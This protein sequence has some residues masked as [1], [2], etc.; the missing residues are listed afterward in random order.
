[1]TWSNAWSQVLVFC[2]PRYNV[3][4]NS[5]YFLHL[6]KYKNLPIIPCHTTR[7]YD[8]WFGVRQRGVRV[9]FKKTEGLGA[10]VI[11]IQKGFLRWGMGAVAARKTKKVA[12]AGTGTVKVKVKP[13]KVI[14]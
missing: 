10:C 2:F 11:A 5:L 6:I 13:A 12:V 8:F 1:M 7:G 14:Q 9:R 3:K 4:I